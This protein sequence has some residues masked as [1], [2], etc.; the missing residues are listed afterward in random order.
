MT[1]IELEFCRWSI[2]GSIQRRNR[3]PAAKR[4]TLDFAK[5]GRTF[6]LSMEPPKARV[7]AR[8][9]VTFVEDGSVVV[10][11]GGLSVS[12]DILVRKRA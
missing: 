8:Q 4:F 6:R 11:V 3:I 12:R 7:F 10:T 1:R 9:V 2:Q 5:S